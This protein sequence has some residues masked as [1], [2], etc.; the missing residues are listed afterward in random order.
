MRSVEASGESARRSAADEVGGRADLS[1]PGFGVTCAEALGEGS[2]QG[3]E[4]RNIS[5]ASQ[6]RLKARGRIVSGALV[7]EI[8]TRRFYDCPAVTGAQGDRSDYIGG[9]SPPGER[10]P[11]WRT[12]DLEIVLADVVIYTKP[13]CPYCYSAMALLKKKGADYVEIV[14]SNDPEKKAEMVERSGRMTFPQIFIND[15][16]VGGSDDLHALDSD[17]KLDSLLAA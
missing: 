6:D 16:H 4:I 15:Q 11:P 1:N 2:R 5:K 9:L 13:G 12:L 17:G 3:G 8:D 14:A 10:R 7:Q